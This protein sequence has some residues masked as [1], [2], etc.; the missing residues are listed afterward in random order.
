MTIPIPYRSPKDHLCLTEVKAIHL[1]QDV[2]EQQLQ[3]I[4]SSFTLALS[5]DQLK[6][7]GA[8]DPVRSAPSSGEK[9]KT[10]RGRSYAK[11]TIYAK[12]RKAETEQFRCVSI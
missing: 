9:S 2:S 6:L 11:R 4:S 5:I 7:P 1:P 12:R 10:G 8:P 3:D